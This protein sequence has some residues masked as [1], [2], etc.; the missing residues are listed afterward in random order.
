VSHSAHSV[1]IIPR[2]LRPFVV[3]RFHEVFWCGVLLALGLLLACVQLAEGASPLKFEL[4]FPLRLYLGL[5]FG[6]LNH[7]NVFL[8]LWC[9][10][11]LVSSSFW[12]SAHFLP[13]FAFSPL[14]VL[15]C[16][17]T[18][19]DFFA[20][21][22]ARPSTFPSSLLSCCLW[23]ACLACCPSGNVGF[24]G[25]A[26]GCLA[27]HFRRLAGLLLAITAACL[28]V[29]AMAR[30]PFQLFPTSLYPSLFR[31]CLSGSHEVPLFCHHPSFLSGYCINWGD[32]AFC[33]SG[34]GASR[35][36]LW[37][38]SL[39]SFLCSEVGRSLLSSHLAGRTLLTLSPPP[40]LCVCHLSSS[41]RIISIS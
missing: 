16:N 19:V 22:Q 7:A 1:R 37:A 18:F 23:V 38:F 4:P 12:V 28:H 26:V 25:C 34:R 31:A 40:P 27:P 11:V 21:S 5:L 13:L 2:P 36:V 29:G 30:L 24:S 32:F 8:T 10:M 15:L 6:P 17:C 35:V 20:F 9:L 41:P 33:L 14:L 39:F 3:L